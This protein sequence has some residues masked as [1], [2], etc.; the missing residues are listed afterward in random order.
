MGVEGPL[1]SLYGHV[2]G[3]GRVKSVSETLPRGRSILSARC[4]DSFNHIL[5]V[6][7]RG[8]GRHGTP[9]QVSSG[10]GGGGRVN[11]VSVR[12]RTRRLDGVSKS[13]G[14]DIE[15]RLG[16]LSRSG[17]EII[18]LL[19]ECMFYVTPHPGCREGEHGG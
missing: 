12:G 3:R 10:G 15:C 14:G 16:G 9:P 11:E 19:P 18:R 7:R 17:G 5:L 8:K 1:E 4:A 6:A 13:N 2:S